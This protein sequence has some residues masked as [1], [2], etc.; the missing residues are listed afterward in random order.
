MNIKLHNEIKKQLKLYGKKFETDFM[1][2]DK[3]DVLKK[4]KD[5]DIEIGEEGTIVYMA[6]KT[7]K[8]TLTTH[9]YL[10]RRLGIDRKLNGTDLVTMSGEINT[11]FFNPY[12]RISLIKGKDIVDAYACNFACSSCMTGHNGMRTDMYAVNED[13]YQMIKADYCNQKARAMLVLLDNGNY[14]MDRVYASSRFIREIMLMYARKKRWW[15]KNGGNGSIMKT[16]NQYASNK[17]VVVSDLNFAN[18]R[19]PY[20]DTLRRGYVK[21]GK[22]TISAHSDYPYRICITSTSGTIAIPKLHPCCVDGCTHSDVSGGMTLVGASKYVC[23]EHKSLF[24]QCRGC[25]Y[26]K[27]KEGM[28]ETTYGFDICANCATHSW[29]QCYSCK[30]Y[31][32]K[33][34]M[35][36]IAEDKLYCEECYNHEFITDD[37]DDDDDDWG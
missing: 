31:E 13:R 8:Q 34:H 36:R 29:T 9:R 19:V 20:Q 24:I 16:F 37:E 1:F 15:F 12:D 14:F 17:D 32:K 7:N 30:T 18:G 11:K 33:N 10:C 21:K 22:L 6:S 27:D 2:I 25:G 28:V 35:H 3:I 4:A 26:W 23:N 5:D